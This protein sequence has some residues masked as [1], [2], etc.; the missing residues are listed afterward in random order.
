MKMI[1]CNNCFCFAPGAEPS[2]PIICGITGWLLDYDGNGEWTQ[3]EADCPLKRMELKD[4]LV[5]EP[6]VI[7]G[8]M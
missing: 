7:D 8:E 6:E 2:I 1:R 3:D 5:Y 4:G